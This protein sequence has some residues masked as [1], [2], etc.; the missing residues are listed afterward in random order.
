M[1]KIYGSAADAL[2]G[3]LHDDILI[4]AGV[5]AFAASPSCC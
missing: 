4:A 5:S 3:L 1:S 2:D